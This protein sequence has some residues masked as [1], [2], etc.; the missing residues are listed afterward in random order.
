[1]TPPTLEAATFRIRLIME[2]GFMRLRI[3]PGSD[4]VGPRR[5]EAVEMTPSMALEDV[6]I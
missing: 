6:W 5:R 3:S 1:M 4:Y 2:R